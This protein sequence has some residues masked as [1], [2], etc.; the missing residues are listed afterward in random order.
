M[1][2]LCWE[3]NL[4]PENLIQ[5]DGKFDPAK[6]TLMELFM[7]LSH[8]SEL[9]VEWLLLGIGPKFVTDQARLD[10]EEV[11]A[12]QAEI[13]L[14]IGTVEV[15]NQTIN[16]YKELYGDLPGAASKGS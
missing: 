10:K 9:S 16:R 11:H 3:G 4:N 5:Q 13:E 7:F 12:L 6:P 2:Q 14:L 8:Y 15:K 1:A